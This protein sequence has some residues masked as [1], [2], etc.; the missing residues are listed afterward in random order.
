MRCHPR[1]PLVVLTTLALVLIRLS[2]SASAQDNVVYVVLDGFRWQEVFTGAEERFITPDA[3][4]KNVNGIRERFWRDTSE[5]RRETL[6]PFLWQTIVK[7]G[8]IFGDPTRGA[9]AR[10]TNSFKFSYPGYN[11]MFVGFADEQIDSNNK[12]NNPNINVLEFL[13]TRDRFK[14]RVAALAT[15]D[16]FPFILNQE[17][18]GIFVHAGT[19]PIVDEPLNERQMLL[20]HAINNALVLWEGNQIDVFTVELTRDYILKHKPKA[21]FLGLGETDE[22]GHGRRYDL[23][24]HAANKADR[25]IQELW[26]LLQ[27]MPE[28]KDNTSLIIS[29]D[30]GR[31]ENLSDW[32]SHGKEIVGAEFVWMAVM[33]PKTPALGIRENVEVTQSQIAATI[34]QLVGE[35]F[36]A[37]VPQAAEPLP[38]VWGE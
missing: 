15:W 23:Y 12:F 14:G 36:R 25:Q 18:S 3:G 11:E 19:G 31:G 6:M 10:L 37:A 2:V 38:G 1:L 29:T 4:V 24:L 21:L 20:N 5:A 34:A 22:W 16:V 17:R 32:T 7:N 30:H 13:N 28:Y 9:A 26:E 8:Q 35:D 27:S 33:G